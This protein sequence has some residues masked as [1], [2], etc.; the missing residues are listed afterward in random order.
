MSAQASEPYGAVELKTNYQKYL[1]RGLLY[2]TILHFVG[3]GIY[4]GSKYIGEEDEPTITV[5][6]VKYSELGPPP[7]I[8]D[9][10]IAPA[11]AVSGAA[12][13]PSIGIPVPV[14]DTE[15]DPAQ[16]IATQAELSQVIAADPGAG[17]IKVED[18]GPPPD[19]VPYEKEP[20]IIK[21]TK[22]LY[23]ELAKRAGVEGTVVL[24]LW[25]DKEGKVRKA[26]VLRS[27][28]TLFEQPA[29]DAAMQFVFTPAM[30]HSGPVSVWVSIPFRF[31]L[32][33]Q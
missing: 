30:Q 26:V 17:D 21:S 10:N 1:K 24:K 32:K 20:Q 27:D 6:V 33:G 7:S 5:R 16:T 9:A 18:E 14:P 15:V 29:I 22:P 4:W 2:A 28:A 11:V 31:Y 19:F 25:V 8:A 12:V 23:P 3:V 13:K